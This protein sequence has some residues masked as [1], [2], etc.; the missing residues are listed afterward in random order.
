MPTIRI[1]TGRVT[2]RRRRKKPKLWTMSTAQR[3]RRP[4]FANKQTITKQLGIPMSP[5]QQV[6]LRSV[7]QTLLDPGIGSSAVVTI[8]ANDLYDPFTAVGGGQPLGFD[9]WMKFYTH[10][11]V[12]EASMKVTFTSTVSGGAV[13]GIVGIR[14]ST[15]NQAITTIPA[16]MEDG[17]TTYKAIGPADSG[18]GIKIVNKHFSHHNFFGRKTYDDDTYRGDTASGP[19]DKAYFQCFYVAQ[20]LLDDPGQVNVQLD[21]TYTAKLTEPRHLVAS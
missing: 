11:V 17:Q 10:F 12:M 4:G 5:A 21:V 19:G 2:R 3:L 16:L 9:E 6:T 14:L 15:D 13:G 7:H 1:K 8:T 20:Q 18:D